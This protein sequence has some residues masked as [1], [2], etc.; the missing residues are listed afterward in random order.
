MPSGDDL[1][2]LFLEDFVRVAYY[3]QKEI[4]LRE[5]GHTQS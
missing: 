5:F 3:S 4:R 1:S 2:L